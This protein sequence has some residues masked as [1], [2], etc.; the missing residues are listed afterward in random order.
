MRVE[1]QKITTNLFFAL[2]ISTAALFAGATP[3]YSVREGLNLRFTAENYKMMRHARGGITYW[4]SHLHLLWV[5][6]ALRIL[7]SNYI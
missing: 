6:T 7:P 2:L 4:F 5:L 3:Q 1:Y